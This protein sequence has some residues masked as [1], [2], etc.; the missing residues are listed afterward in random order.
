MLTIEDVLTRTEGPEA[1]RALVKRAYAFAHAAHEG[2]RRKSG[3]PYIQHCLAVA[4]LLTDVRLDAETIAAALLHDVVEDTGF[5]ISDLEKEFGPAIANMV[6]G[7]TKLEKKFKQIDSL[8][9]ELEDERDEQETES[10][11]KMFLAMARDAR[12]TL[13]KLADRLHNMRTLEPLTYHRRQALASETM[14]IYAPLAYRL[15]V[16]RWKWQLEDLAF[17]ELDPETYERIVKKLVTTRSERQVEINTHISLLRHHLWLEGIQADIQGRPKH[18][19][20]IYRK[21]QRKHVG[22]EQVYDTQAV[23]V[24]VDSVADCYHV[25]GVVH[26]LWTPIPGEFDDYI[27]TPKDN[28]YQSLHIAVRGLEGKTLEVQI[29]T[30]HMHRIAENG[31][32]AHWQYKEGTLRHDPLFE[33]QIANLRAQIEGS[34]SEEDA[35]KFV[36]ALKEEFFQDRVYTLTPKG[37]I[38]D[39]PVG[40]TPIDF[41]YHIHTEI[42]H[43]ARGAKV[44]GRWMGL[45]YALRTGDQVEIVT[46]K[47]AAP[48]RDWLNPALGYV[49]TGRA[50]SKIR[51]WLRKQDREKNIAIGRA[52]LE[53]ELRRLGMDEMAHEAVAVLMGYEDLN[54]FLAAIGF[55]DEHS[56]HIASKILEAQQAEARRKIL[57]AQERDEDD[58]ETQDQGEEQRPLPQ[59]EHDIHVLGTGG[60]LTR[61]A[62]CCNPI[63]GEPIIGYVTRGR[64]ITVHRRDCPNVINTP[65]TERLIEVSWGTETHTFPVPLVV[66]VYDRPGLLHDITGEIKDGG[67]NI[68]SVTVSKRRNLANIYLT[69]EISDVS[70]LAWVLTRIGRL[71][72]VIEVRRQVQ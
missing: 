50:R 44:N 63:R 56:H 17:Q 48:S 69:L 27:A 58:D 57:E 46:A 67:I 38:I 19:Y 47:K 16:W 34:N 7:V 11:R 68:S 9:R 54:D 60:F 28:G 40:S 72:N 53:R 1:D 36:E 52:I 37:K 42:G 65:D 6:D 70:Q 25:M 2:Q 62:Q 8:G 32:A 59:V 4:M 41:A 45:D 31:I 10:L 5:S 24:I 61:M 22:L 15:G 51:Q 12:V 23:R 29:R 33:R 55:G 26:G 20:S 66:H 30:H 35:G 21:M 14:T 71:P 64:G 3:E 49:K 39:L 18:I 13:I 43:R